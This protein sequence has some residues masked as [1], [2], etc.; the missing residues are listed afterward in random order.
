V[1]GK[2]QTLVTDLDYRL[3]A[4]IEPGTTV[5]TDFWG[6]YHNLEA[7]GY[8]HLT[9]NHSIGFVHPDTGAH[10]YTTESYCRHLKAYLNPYN[11]QADYIYEIAHYMFAARCKAQKVDQFTKFLHLGAT[12]D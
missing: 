3:D 5:I 7:Q 4:W 8:K 9:V 2:N 11:R 10:T 6:A 1:T 12:T